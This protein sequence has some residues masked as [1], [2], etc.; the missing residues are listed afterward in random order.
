MSAADSSLVP[1]PKSPRLYVAPLDGIAIH[2]EQDVSRA[3]RL[4]DLIERQGRLE[5]PVIVCRLPAPAFGNGNS[6]PFVHLDG[7]N[8]LTSLRALGCQMVAVQVVDL[9]NPA[10]VS[11]SSWAHRM[12]VDP[13]DFLAYLRRLPG[14]DI[15]RLRVWDNGG[16][17]QTDTA[18][19]VFLERSAFQLRLRSAA[20][21]NRVEVLR[22]MV[23]YYA[24]RIERMKLPLCPDP[25]IVAKH[26]NSCARDG[27]N[28]L[29]TFPP[30][31]PGDFLRLAAQHVP[32]PPGITRFV[33]SGGRA[34]GIDIPLHLLTPDACAAKIKRWLTRLHDIRPVIIPPQCRVKEY[35]G[36]RDYED[37]L[38]V[39]RAEF[40]VSTSGDNCRLL[41]WGEP[42]ASSGKR[43]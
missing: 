16:V 33:L 38:L 35:M 9:E 43:T 30:F 5:N 29:V 17:D 2:E 23:A 40:R 26:L 22:G 42:R 36:W 37:P 7:A 6:S 12:R 41:E 3:P 8:R 15:Q 18:A 25:R 1:S 13:C 34:M 27:A 19:F 11:L 20:L 32:A 31:Q 39:Y 21:I 14:L 10:D 4:R 24:A 28:M